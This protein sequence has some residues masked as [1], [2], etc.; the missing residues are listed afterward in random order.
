MPDLP[1][2]ALP[3]GT[4]KSRFKSESTA[5]PKC[6][7]CH[8]ETSHAADLALLAY[9]LSLDTEDRYAAFA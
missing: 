5:A 7:I 8:T 1:V 4:Q 2:L 6:S 3:M 9:H